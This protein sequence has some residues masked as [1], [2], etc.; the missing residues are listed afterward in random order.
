MLLLL[1]VVGKIHD[2]IREMTAFLC[3]RTKSFFIAGLYFGSLYAWTGNLAIPLIFHGVYD[4]LALLRAH[5]TIVRMTESQRG[6]VWL[7]VVDDDDDENGTIKG[8]SSMV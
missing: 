1:P 3:F 7:G 2:G 6:D 8:G 4:D 5:R